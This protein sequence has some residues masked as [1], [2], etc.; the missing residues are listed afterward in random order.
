MPY[1][2]GFVIPVETANRNRYIDHVKRMDKFMLENGARRIVEA[3]GD[4]VPNGMLTDFHRAVAAE[5][6]EDDGRTDALRSQPRDLRR[7]RAR[8]CCGEIA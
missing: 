8:D 6:G 2:D 7:F 1:I 5:A 4:D 3:W